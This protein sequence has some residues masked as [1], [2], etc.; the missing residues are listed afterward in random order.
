[1]TYPEHRKAGSITR[2][3]LSRQPRV[4]LFCPQDADGLTLLSQLQ[5]I[6]CNVEMHWPPLQEVRSDI[7]LIFLSIQPDVEETNYDW[8]HHNPPPVISIS[9]FENPTIIDE[10]LRIGVMGMLTAPI[11]ATGLLSALIMALSHRRQRDKDAMRIM[12]L[13]SKFANFRIVEDA[14]IIL[15]RMQG[16]DES[17]AYELLRS[18]A[19]ALRLAVEDVAK[20]LIH[21][22]KVLSQTVMGKASKAGKAKKK[23]QGNAE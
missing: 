1:M 5:R 19:M 10:A 21:A 20:D 8:L 23:V 16:I 9:S 3:I 12:R 17:E 2:S 18:Q 22:D 14:K 11:R 15:M 7:D 13:E 6:G 4:L